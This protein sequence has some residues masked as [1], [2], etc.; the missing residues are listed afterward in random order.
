MV[1]YGRRF[2]WRYVV[3]LPGNVN[4]SID[5]MAGLESLQIDRMIGAEDGR[6]MQTVHVPL[7]KCALHS[8]R[9]KNYFTA[10]LCRWFSSYRFFIAISNEI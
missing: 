2:W 8:M 7:P 6:Q 10:I 9:L 4:L 3:L 1:S 5:D